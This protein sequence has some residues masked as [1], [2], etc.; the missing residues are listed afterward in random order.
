MHSSDMAGQEMQVLKRNGAREGVSFDKITKRLRSLGDGLCVDPIRVCQKVVESLYDGV[1]TSELDELSA[2]IAASMSL[3]HPDYNAFAGRIASSNH[4]KNTS[5]SFHKTVKALYEATDIN[6]DHSPIVSKDLYDITKKHRK[7]IEDAIDYE[8]DFLYD[9]FGFQTLKRSYLLRINGTCVERVQGMWM[10]VALGIHGD[11]I[12]SALETYDLMSRKHFTHA[13]PTLFNA[14]TPRPQLSSCFLMGMDDSIEGIFKCLTDCALVSKWAGGI[15]IHI[16]DIRAR[17]SHIRGTNGASNGLVPLLR[18]FNATARFV[19]QCI[20]E[21]DVF[22]LSGPR[23]IAEI[24]YGDQVLGDDG[25]F[26]RVRRVLEHR[27]TGKLW[28]LEADTG[29]RITVTGSQRV[30]VVRCLKEGQDPRRVPPQWLDVCDLLVG[31]HLVLPLPVHEEDIEELTAEDCAVYG[32]LL[33][34]GGEKPYSVCLPQS[35]SY[36]L[37][38]YFESRAIPFTSVPMGIFV[39][40]TWE[41]CNQFPLKP[42]MWFDASTCSSRL[43]PAIMHLPP[44]KA[45]RV[46]DNFLQDGAPFCGHQVA[47]GIQHMLLKLGKYARIPGSKS[48]CVFP[49]IVSEGAALVPIR[50]LIS[51]LARDQPVFDLVLDGSV[52]YGTKISLLHHGLSGDA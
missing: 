38:A 35:R 36:D 41:P 6:G 43:C 4:Q 49:L 33:R 37:E 19:D 25:A 32:T 10:R 17:G 21:G 13:T 42:A 14:G 50:S 44:S 12:S 18:T 29:E 30:W 5:P 20:A 2:Q 27:Y 26:H 24:V 16:H 1:T 51:E 47:S 39:L 31:D 52:A 9:Y 15:G 45:S 48:S 22:T 8:R 23:P 7:E 11:D 46:V 34:Y 40:L 28:H 3:E